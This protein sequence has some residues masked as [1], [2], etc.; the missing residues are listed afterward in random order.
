M[1]TAEDIAEV[2]RGR[3]WEAKIVEESK[4]LVLFKTSSTGLFEV[5]R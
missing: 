2:L 3:D 4:T 1:V 5:C